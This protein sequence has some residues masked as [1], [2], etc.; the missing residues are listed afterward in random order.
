MIDPR[1]YYYLDYSAV[2]PSSVVSF[3][4]LIFSYKPISV[5]DGR[6]IV[7]LVS[8]LLRFGNLIGDTD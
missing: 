6:S 4:L 3:L 5:F 8:A 7:A 1:L 2:V